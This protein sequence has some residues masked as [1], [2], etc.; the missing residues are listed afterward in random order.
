MLRPT[1]R[2]H[3]VLLTKQTGDCSLAIHGS[4]SAESRAHLSTFA[5]MLPNKS[6]ALLLIPSLHCLSVISARHAKVTSPSM[7]SW[8]F[9]MSIACACSGQR[10]VFSGSPDAHCQHGS[11]KALAN[12]GWAV[13][14]PAVC[15]ARCPALCTAQR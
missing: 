8:Q 14:T 11:V 7:E 1:K 9:V 10:V 6:N 13:C 2:L 12:T 15:A 3:R 5:K 4:R